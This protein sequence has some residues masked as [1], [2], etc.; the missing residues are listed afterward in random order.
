M[1]NKIEYIVIELN[2]PSEAALERYHK[3]V[4]EM[5]LKDDRSM[6]SEDTKASK[7]EVLRK[8]QQQSNRGVI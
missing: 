7:R 4:C 6:D 3:L 1:K 2:K 8:L 5:I